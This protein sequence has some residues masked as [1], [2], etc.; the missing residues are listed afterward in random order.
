[1][2]GAVTKIYITQK[3]GVT[4]EVLIDTDDLAHVSTHP[5]AWLVKKCRRHHF[6]VW[7][8]SRGRAKT[9]FIYL[10]RYI[11]NAPDGYVVDHI[12]NN[13]LDNRKVNLRVVTHKANQQNREGAQKNN[14]LGVRGVSWS[15]SHKKWVVQLNSREAYVAKYFDNLDEAKEAALAFRA[16]YYPYSKEAL[17]IWTS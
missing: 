5:F 4:H 6:R 13:P 15:K 7:S 10:H 9:K 17:G 1:V 8:N 14:K 3:S 16:L 2:C 12:N 11:L